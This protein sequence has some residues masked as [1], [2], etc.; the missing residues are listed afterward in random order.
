MARKHKKVKQD[1]QTKLYKKI[2]LP[3]FVSCIIIIGG[4]I[5]IFYFYLIRQQYF[6][7]DD[8]LYQWYPFFTYIKDCFK[9]FKLPL[10]NPYSF[11]GTPAAND[12]ILTFYPINWLFLFLNG[13]SMLTFYQVELMILFHL[14]LVGCFAFLM[15]KECGV[16]WQ[17][18]IL[19]STT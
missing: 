19:G 2:S 4:L 3:T 13:G 5:I 9:N 8:V 15:F 10:W 1:I 18:R 16:G 7:W 14:L 12:L 11:A 6:L 17:I